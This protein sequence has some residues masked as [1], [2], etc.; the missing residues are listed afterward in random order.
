MYR[1]VAL[2]LIALLVGFSAGWK[3]QG[4]RLG[5]QISTLKAEAEQKQKDLETA[6]REATQANREKE[7]LW[8]KKLADS[9][10]K[11]NAEVANINRRLSTAL[12]ELRNRPERPGNHNPAVSSTAPACVGATGTELARGD[13]EFLAGYAADAAKLEAELNKCEAAYNSIIQQR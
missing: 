3:T 10:E 11:R 2:G 9:Q 1:Y 5:Q 8:V 7:Q 13:A 12:I 6:L 4:W